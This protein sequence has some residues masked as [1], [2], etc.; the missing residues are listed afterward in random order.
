M[1]EQ[2]RSVYVGSGNWG[3]ETGKIQVFTLDVEAASLSSVQVLDAGGVAAFM[4]RSKDGRR[5][6]VADETKGVLSSYSIEPTTGA[7]ERTSTVPC[8]G[9]PVYVSLDA[10]DGA[11]LTCFFEEAKT[12]IFRIAPDGTLGEATCLVDSGRESHCTVFD[13]SHR[14]LFV[15]T[16]GD[17]W[18]A[19]YRYDAAR[20]S[21]APNEPAHVA[22]APGAGPRHLAFHPNGRWAY[23]VNELTLT[24]SVFAFDPE[25][26]TLRSTV[27]DLPIA[28]PGLEGGSSAD[29]HVHPNGKFLYVSNRQSDQSNLA[30][31]SVDPHGGGVAVIGHEPTRGRTPRNFALD[32]EGRI[33]IAGNQ[34]SSDVALFRIDPGSGRLA[35]VRSVPVSP[36]PFFVGIY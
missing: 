26:G 36:G 32:P 4:A 19:Q 5:L 23:L 21:L 35:F 28:P 6:Y 2:R 7:L 30:I 15:P 11:L 9:H 13:P 33:L 25:R 31:V 20:H 18:I 22:E 27:R 29:V 24:L 12:Q 10:A 16:R 14:F 3:G 8:A 17:N 34:D 1:V